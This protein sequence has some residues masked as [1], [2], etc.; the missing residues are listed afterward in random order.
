MAFRSYNI[1]ATLRVILLALMILLFAYLAFETKLMLVA[2]FIGLVVIYQVYDLLAFVHTTNRDLKR[3]LEA[4]RH[5][6]FSQNFNRSGFGKSFRELNDVFTEV[7]D[8]FRKERL[9]KEEQNQYLQTILKHISVGLITYYDDG[10][11]DLIN[12]AAKDLLHVDNLKSLRQLRPLSMELTNVLVDLQNGGR[13][14]VEVEFPQGEVKQ[15]AAFASK[16]ILRARKYTVVSLQDIKGELE[17]E[18]MSK[19]LEIAHQVQMKLLPQALPKIEGYEIAASCD[20]AKEVGGDFYDFI[21]VE[22]GRHGIALGDVSGKGTPAAIYMTLTKGYF[23][24][25]ALVNS[26]PKETLGSIDE[27]LCSAMDPGMFVTMLY[28]ML[29][30]RSDELRYVRAG[31]NPIIHYRAAS[32]DCTMEKPKGIA[33]G[34]SGHGNFRRLAEE[35]NVPLHAGDIVLFYTDG[36]T[37]TMNRTQEQFGEER[38]IG[39]LKQNSGASAAEL[40]NI[41]AKACEEFAAGFEQHDDMTII[42]LKKV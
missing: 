9:E 3:F 10:E 22:G 20:P 11:V 42:V 36:L 30:T 27:Y 23:Q 12:R 29:D 7:M 4:V 18:R 21:T 1:K 17:R 31:H 34:M 38:L 6:D 19:E 2:G 32:K 41:I 15:L 25:N 28:G 14:L 5:S 33:L 13:A 39:L 26:S 16:F 24:S 40:M 8:D 35:V 37:E